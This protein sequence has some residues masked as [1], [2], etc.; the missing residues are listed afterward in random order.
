MIPALSPSMKSSGS[1]TSKKIKTGKQIKAIALRLKKQGRKIAFTNGCFDILHYGH[2][3]YLEAARAMAGALVVGV[4]SDAS[5][6]RIK[7]KNRPI[8]S[9][10]DR[11]RVLSGLACVDYV[12]IFSED[13]PL[14][15]LHLVRPDVLIKGGDWAVEKIAGAPFV[16]A[17]GGKVAAIEYLPGYSTTKL[18]KKISSG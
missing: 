5:V 18:I 2:V 7:G 1:V 12:V 13:T 11:A 4:N 14:E 9:E 3:Q 15:L 17:Y 8:N 6:K 10:L 16:R